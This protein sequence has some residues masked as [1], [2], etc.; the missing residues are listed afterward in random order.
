MVLPPILMSRKG[1]AAFAVAVAVVLLYL[2]GM[3]LLESY[4]KSQY[5]LG[6][7]EGVASVNKR[8]QQYRDRLAEIEEHDKEQRGVLSAKITTLQAEL[9]EALKQSEARRNI[10]RVVVKE[11]TKYVTQKADTACTLPA[12]A[13]WMWNRAVAPESPEA[14]SAVANGEPDDVDA[15]SGVALSTA[16][17]I[18]TDN[19]GECVQR[20]EVIKAW[21]KWYVENQEAYENYR[22]TVA[23]P[24]ELKPQ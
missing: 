7:Q 17:G 12:G 1:W 20:G 4:G 15:P 22:K 10:V 14:A 6:H 16:S 21:Q 13:V 23:K 5:N 2:W 8:I 11:V 3:A 19:L 9:E 24:P 18:V